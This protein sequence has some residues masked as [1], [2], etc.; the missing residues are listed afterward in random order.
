VN[1]FVY[2]RWGASPLAP[3]QIRY[4]L[5]HRQLLELL[6][7]RFEILSDRTVAPRGHGGILRIANSTKLNRV[8]DVILGPGRVRSLKER[9]GLGHC[10]VIVGRAR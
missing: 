5:T 10:R 2:E 9:L 7:P 4:W 8:L 1:P 6:S 3:G